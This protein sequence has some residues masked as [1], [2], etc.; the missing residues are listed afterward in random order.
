MVNRTNRGFDSPT[1][2]LGRQVSETPIST[3][4]GRGEVSDSLGALSHAADAFSNGMHQMAMR[5]AG[6]EGEAQAVA[7]LK[8]GSPKPQNPDTAFGASY[9]EVV[10]QAVGADRKAALLTDINKALLDNP[11][12]PAAFTKAAQAA[13]AGYGT[14]GFADLDADLH[15]FAT[16][17]IGAG[18]AKAQEGQYQRKADTAKAAFITTL[19]SE[20]ALIGHTVTTASFDPAGSQLVAAQLGRT[21]SN[22]AKYGPREAFEISGQKFEADPA[23]LGVLGVDDLAKTYVDL[24]AEARTDWAISAADNLPD[25]ASKKAFLLDVEK[26]YRGNDPMFAAMDRDHYDHMVTRIEGLANK[27]ETSERVD[28]AQAGQ[29]ARDMIE[30]LNWGH[31]VDDAQLKSRA[32]ASGDVGLIAQADVMARI[33][34]QVPAIL[35]RIARRNGGGDGEDGEGW[36]MPPGVVPGSAEFV[37]WQNTKEGF[38]SDPLKFAHGTKKRAALAD[39]APLVPDGFAADGQA[40]A[41][42]A[43]AMQQRAGVG[44]QLS[45]TYGVPMRMLTNGDKAYYQQRMAQDPAYGVALAQA[46]SRA[47]GPQGAQAL[48]SELGAGNDAP[49]SVHLGDLAAR[50]ST[51]IVTSA[52]EGQALRAQG[53]KDQPAAKGGDGL[54]GLQTQWAAAF[55]QSPQVL[56]AARRVAEDARLADRLKGVT[57]PDLYY[58]NGAVGAVSGNGRVRGGVAVVN[59]R[60]TVLPSWLD[61]EGGGDALKALAKVWTTPM[62]KTPAA[63]PVW[64]DGTPLKAQDIAKLQ[65]VLLPDG[66]YGLVHPKTNQVARNRKGEP[67]TFDIDAA[68]GQLGAN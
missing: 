48:M 21:M 30:A 51:R 11:A 6:R 49:V 54:D 7:D 12:D 23:R 39:V 68:R 35:R 50:G 25:A 17:Q 44:A 59:G 53:A 66:R 67:F 45:Q 63:G 37:A 16:V 64:S 33:G 38:S 55:Q 31:D 65:M 46:A 15:N 62:P 41:Y 24:Q 5:A 3:E 26:R 4:T 57:H 29:D 2:N 40:G 14:S 58:L 27:A 36:E 28:K 43:A 34:P 60:Q 1:L 47:I 20:Q 19:K 61:H 52:L 10:K 56:V 8:T 42:W 22:L 18:V 13:T 9:G 32:K